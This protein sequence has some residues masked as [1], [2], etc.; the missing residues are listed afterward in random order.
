MTPQ[1]NSILSKL[2][3]A[4]Q[5]QF[6]QHYSQVMGQAMA[7]ATMPYTPPK[8]VPVMRKPDVYEQG[9]GWIA[10]IIGGIAWATAFVAL[11][12]T[13]NLSWYVVGPIGFPAI[14]AGIAEYER[15]RHLHERKRQYMADVMASQ[16]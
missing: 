4:Q 5:A 6:Q 7:N 15:R 13:G 8:P 11:L 14:T 12:F 2:S 16:A 9:C 1:Q 10:I 3:P